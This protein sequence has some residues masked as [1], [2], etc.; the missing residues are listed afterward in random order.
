MSVLFTDTDCEMDWR[1]VEKYNIHVMGM[2]YILD[3]EEKVYDMGKD[4]EVIHHFYKRVKEGAMPLTAALNPNDYVN[5]FEPIFAAGE[6]IFYIHFSNELSGTFKYMQMAL[7]QLKEKYPERKVTTFDTKSICLGA[8]IQVLE[9]AKLKANGATDEEILAFLENFSKHICT[10][11]MVDSLSHL[12]RGGRISSAAAVIG[13]LL[14]IKPI[15]HLTD[16]GKIVKVG[17][18]NGVKKTIN[19]MANTF[20]Q[21]YLPD[22]EYSIY[23]VDAENGNVAD[24]LANA[25]RPYIKN[26]NVKIERLLI[27]PVIG[28]HCGPG[29]VGLIYYSAKR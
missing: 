24:S 28:T 7:E 20:K 3:G 16:D 27:G 22:N 13:G 26:K 14:N 25:I 21:N 9:A 11:F 17:A 29:S 1:D 12:R 8:G 5:Y 2:P 10:T 15:L 23:I 19:I 6:D 4:E 18:G